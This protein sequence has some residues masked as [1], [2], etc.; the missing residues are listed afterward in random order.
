VGDVFI[1]NGTMYK[2]L[3]YTFVKPGFS[4]SLYYMTIEYVDTG[5]TSNLTLRTSEKVLLVTY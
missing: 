2:L 3:K 4:V 1:Y 5:V